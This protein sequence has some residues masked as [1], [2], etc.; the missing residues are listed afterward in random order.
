ML[1]QRFSIAWPKLDLQKHHLPA[2]FLCAERNR[3]LLVSFSSLTFP[4]CLGASLFLTFLYGYFDV[5]F[6]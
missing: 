1:L 4:P 2:C 5:L 3:L 6:R